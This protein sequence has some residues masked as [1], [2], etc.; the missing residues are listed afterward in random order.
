MKKL[1]YKTNINCNSCIKSVSPFLNELENIDL[2]K[3]DIENPD[4]I[5]EVTL[6]DDNETLVIDA[7]KK[8][9]FEIEPLSED[10]R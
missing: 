3:V 1:R 4:K 7:V 5:L 8:A 10:M 6:E 2:W 9:G